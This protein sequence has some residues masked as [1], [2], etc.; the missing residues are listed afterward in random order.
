MRG[1]YLDK[2]ESR[3]LIGNSG[4]GKTHLT[5]ALAFTACALGRKVSFHTV[6]GLVTELMECREE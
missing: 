4:T 3:L 1:D 2:K 5:C 6:T